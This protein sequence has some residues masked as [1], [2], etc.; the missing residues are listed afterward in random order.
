MI[1]LL[2]A[3]RSAHQ[4]ARGLHGHQRSVNSTV[5]TSQIPAE[6][7]G[8]TLRARLGS[9]GIGNVY[10]SF[11]PGRP[12]ALKVVRREFAGDPEFRRRFR[13]GS[14]LARS[15]GGRCSP[16]IDA[17][18]DA[19]GG[20][21]RPRPPA[22]PGAGEPGP[23]RVTWRGRAGPAGLPGAG[24]PGPR[25]TW[26]G[27][28]GPAGLPG[29]GEPGPPGYLARAS[30]A[31][32]VTWRGRAGPA[33]LPGAGEPGPPGARPASPA[34]RGNRGRARSAARFPVMAGTDT[35]TAMRSQSR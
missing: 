30:R 32:R 34:A 31:R 18:G 16:G 33:G 5:L 10:L 2:P 11:T 26:R 25:V 23:R 6:I 24:E 8:Y 1:M 9:G 7:A 14:P 12:V 35:I 28:A 4:A 22:L 29:A 21:I 15:P 3:G 13:R 20:R 19:G 17:A 27:R